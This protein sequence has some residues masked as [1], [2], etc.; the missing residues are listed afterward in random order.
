MSIEKI[1]IIG[2]MTF[3]CLLAIGG[4]IDDAVRPSVACV[5]QW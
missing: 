4:I 2:F 3:F 1:F 5:K